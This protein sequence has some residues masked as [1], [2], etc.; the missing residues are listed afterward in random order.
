MAFLPDFAYSPAALLHTAL[1]SIRRNKLRSFLSVLG[2]VFGV[3]AVMTIICVG[4]GA[5]NEALRSVEQ[6]GTRNIYLRQLDLSPEQKAAAGARSMEGLSTD[7]M[8]RIMQAGA[9]IRQAACLREIPVPVVGALSQMAP[10][11]AACSANYADL[12]NLPVTAGRFIRQADMNRHQMVCVLGSEVAERLGASGRLHRNLR[13][14]SHLFTIVGRLGRVQPGDSETAAVSV[15]NHNEMI[16]LPMGARRWLAASAPGADRS[17]FE[18]SEI[19]IESSDSSRVLGNAALL[20]RILGE[21]RSRFSSCQMVVPLELLH[22]SRRTDEMF[23]LFLAAIAGVSLVVGGIGI[24]NIMLATI[25]ERKKEIGI[26]RAVGATRAHILMQF[27]AESTAL[28]LSGGVIGVLFG[29]AAARTIS[30]FAP[31]H[32]AISPEAVLAPLAMA[33][34]VGLF[35]GLYPAYR[36][37]GVDPIQALKYE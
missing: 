31:W 30:L 2:V 4:Q 5:R 8:E 18:L 29:A 33:I 37:A 3:M 21:D 14:G 10:Q 28:T 6:L 22:Q 24:M 16:F 9:H 15:R 25:S 26:R 11:V 1:S 32:A 23:N 19:I 17:G 35:F 20:R 27:L 34:V 13:I 7:D 12:L 36:A